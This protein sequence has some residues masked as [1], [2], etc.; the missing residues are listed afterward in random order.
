MPWL[1]QMKD[2][3]HNYG[4]TGENFPTMHFVR[5]TTHLPANGKNS[6]VPKLDITHSKVQASNPESTP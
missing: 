3:F 6:D 5:S 4:I 2:T 1:L